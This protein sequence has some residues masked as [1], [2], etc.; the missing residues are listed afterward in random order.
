LTDLIERAVFDVLREQA[1]RVNDLFKPK[2][3][4]MLHDEIRVANWCRACQMRNVSAGNYWPKT[5]LNA[6]EFL[7]RSTPP[8]T[9]SFGRML[10]ANAKTP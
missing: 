5:W 7:N 2:T 8:Q 1:R 6:S 4:F 10:A 9:S 3:F